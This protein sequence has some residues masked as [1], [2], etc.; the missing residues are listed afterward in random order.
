MRYDEEPEITDCAYCN[1]EVIVHEVPAFD[2]DN[3]WL[4]ESGQHHPDCE[5]IATRAHQLPE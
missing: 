2:Y 1:A 3:G 4:T 5:W